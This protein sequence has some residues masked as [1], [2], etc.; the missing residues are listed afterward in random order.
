MAITGHHRYWIL[1]ILCP[2]TFITYSFAVFKGTMWLLYW[3]NIWP[4]AT[5]VLSPLRCWN[6][7]FCCIGE[8][9]L[10]QSRHNR[11][12]FCVGLI[13]VK[14]AYWAC[15]AMETVPTLTRFS[16]AVR[17]LT[18]A[19]RLTVVGITL[20]TPG[21]LEKWWGPRY[22]EVEGRG[23]LDVNWFNC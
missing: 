6:W 9:G 23:A 14:N 10:T 19:T 15:V 2:C 8:H 1:W 12:I 7:P 17:A 4:H 11:T 22:Q 5:L 16:T 3:C 18:C 20:L 13:S 21:W